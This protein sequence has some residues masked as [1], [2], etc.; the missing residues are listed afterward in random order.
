MSSDGGAKWADPRFV[1][2][3]GVIG[4]RNQYNPSISIDSAGRLNV[5][6]L[7]R[8]DDVNDCLTREYLSRSAAASDIRAF[9]DIKISNAPSNFEVTKEGPGY[10]N[11]NGPGDYTGVTSIDTT[12]FPYFPDVRV[13]DWTGG[14]VPGEIYTSDSAPCPL[15]F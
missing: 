6:Y 9:D 5:A 10:G 13:S 3:G 14:S 11:P 1:S 2:Q 7:D 15:C 8:R 4:G 12:T